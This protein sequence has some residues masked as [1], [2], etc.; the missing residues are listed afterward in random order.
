MLSLESPRWAELQ[1][2][3]GT[4]EDIPRLLDALATL[5]DPT[6]RAEVW[7]ALWRML[8]RPDAVFNAAYAAAPHLLDVAADF[9]LD[10]RTEAIHFVARIEVMRLTPGAPPIPP[11]LIADYASA[12]ESLPALVAGA[13]GEPWTPGIAQILAAAMLIGKRQGALA[14]AVLELGNEER[15]ARAE[16]A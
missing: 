3:Y 16:G 14:V 12:V 1:Q 9:E 6:A 10:E 4:A 2:G 13:L 7:F 5:D 8:C 15:D 11:D